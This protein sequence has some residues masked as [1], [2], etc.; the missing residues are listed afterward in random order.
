MRLWDVETLEEDEH[1]PLPGPTDRISGLAVGPDHTLAASTANGLIYLWDAD[2]GKAMGH[3]LAGNLGL[4]RGL[5]FSPEGRMLASGNG[6]SVA[7]WDLTDLEEGSGLGKVLSS[8]QVVL[9][10]AFSPDGSTLALRAQ[11]DGEEA[12]SEIQ[13]LQTATGEPLEPLATYPQPAHDLTFSPEGALLEL[14]DDQERRE[15]RRWDLAK[16]TST[17]LASEDVPR[18]AGP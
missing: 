17:V 18:G 3:P 2:T 4:I 6:S 11:G 13:L 9:D 5:G 1:S 15:I 10:L 16:R 7:L 14:G 12:H 8:G